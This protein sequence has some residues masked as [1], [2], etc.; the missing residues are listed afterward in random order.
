MKTLLERFE[1]KYI[2]EPMSGCWLWTSTVD[3]DG[4]GKIW[5][6]RKLLLAHRVAYELFKGPIPDGLCVLHTCDVPAC[7][8]PDHLWLG[9]KTDNNADM[10]A[11]GRQVNGEQHGSA[12]LTESQVLE[13]RAATESSRQIA[14]RYGI[15]YS[16]VCR[17]RTRQKWRHLK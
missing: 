15:D 8:N 2:P 1:E 7:V 14:R 12:K 4:Y 9:T 17:I 13:I 5:G 3:K 11:K 6:N 16:H 10:C